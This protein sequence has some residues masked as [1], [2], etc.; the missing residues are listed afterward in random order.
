MVYVLLAVVIV[1]VAVFAVLATS[2]RTPSSNDNVADFQRHL[3]ALSPEARRHTV[4][5]HPDMKS[6]DPLP[7]EETEEPDNGA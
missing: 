2:R 7:I 3:N 6:V 5:N 1:C 4:E